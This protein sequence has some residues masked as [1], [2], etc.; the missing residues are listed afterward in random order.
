MISDIPGMLANVFSLWSITFQPEFYKYSLCLSQFL[1]RTLGC[2]G[3]IWVL[4]AQV[5]LN[6]TYFST[7]EWFKWQDAENQYE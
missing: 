1:Q 3:N 2:S 5:S 6:K 7:I 4:S